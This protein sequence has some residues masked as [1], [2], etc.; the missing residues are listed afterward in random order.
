MGGT[1]VAAVAAGP[2]PPRSLQPLPDFERNGAATDRGRDVA[3]P[4]GGTGSGG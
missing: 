4:V 1:L 2:L 3:S